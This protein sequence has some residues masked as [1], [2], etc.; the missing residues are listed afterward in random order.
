MRIGHIKFVWPSYFYI[1]CVFILFIS[2]LTVAMSI[3]ECILQA[4]LSE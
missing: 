4:Y 1:I 2:E 3:T